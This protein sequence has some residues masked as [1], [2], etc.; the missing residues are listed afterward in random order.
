MKI[1]LEGK[2]KL[3]S[4]TARSELHGEERKAAS[5][6][7]IEASMPNDFLSQL[8]PS[9]KSALYAFDDARPKDLA[10]QGQAREAGHLPHLKF[11]LL[12]GPLK[13]SEEMES[14][15]VSLKLPGS[16]SEV[17]LEEVKV[18]GIAFTPKDGGTIELSIRVQAHPDK[19][20]FGELASMVQGEVE[21]TIT[22]EE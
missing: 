22:P 1:K 9:L 19:K 13:W 2:G 3:A 16:K 18:N 15:T 20:Q 6:L 5:D 4:V 7:K 21:F 17:V 14:A 8:H 10:D 12:E 11:A